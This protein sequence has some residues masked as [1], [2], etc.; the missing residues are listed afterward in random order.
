MTSST[1]IS[2]LRRQIAVIEEL[3]YVENYLTELKDFN[4]SLVRLTMLTYIS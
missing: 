3:D 4:M 1:G 2:N